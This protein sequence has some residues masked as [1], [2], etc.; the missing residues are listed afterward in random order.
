[1]KDY[2]YISGKFATHAI[3]LEFVYALLLSYDECLED[4]REDY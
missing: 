2:Q 1:V 3:R 4:K